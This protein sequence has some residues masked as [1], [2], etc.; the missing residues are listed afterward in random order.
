L[1]M[2]ARSAA[3]ASTLRL[4][5]DGGTAADAHTVLSDKNKN[6]MKSRY[7]MAIPSLILRL[8]YKCFESTAGG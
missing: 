8:E 5:D 4:I 6:I 3:E 2:A 1:I 7:I